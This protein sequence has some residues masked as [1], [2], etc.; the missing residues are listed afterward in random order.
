MNL[1]FLGGFGPAPLEPGWTEQTAVA[2]LG[3]GEFD[4]TDAPPGPDARLRAYAILG[5]IEIKVPP[6]THVRLDGVSILGGRE[7][8]VGPGDG[9]V[10]HVTAVAVLGGIT[11]TDGR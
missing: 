9:P 7:V 11:V 2:V 4:L 5:G 8:K 6:G 10:V 3:G 1:A